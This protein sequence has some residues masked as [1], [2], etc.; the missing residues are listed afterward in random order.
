M[1]NTFDGIIRRARDLGPKVLAVAA[2]ED[3]DVLKAVHHAW[4]LGIIV[5]LLVG[6][7][8]ETCRAAGEEGLNITRF[9]ILPISDKTEACSKA[10]QLV[11]S[12]EASL[13][14]KGF[15]DTAVILKALLDKESGLMSGGLFSHVGVLSIKGYD[16]FFILSDSAMNLAPTLEEK[17]HIIRNAV[18][19]AHALGNPLP[20][21]AVL[22][23]VEKVNPKMQCTLDAAELV[24]MNEAG[25]IEGCMVGGPFALDNAV[26]P[27]AAQHKGIKHPVAGN[28]D[29]LI[30]PDLEAGNLLNKSMEY[31]AFAE[32]AGII[33]G[34]AAP[35]VLTSR[36]SSDAS[37]LNSIALAVLAAMYC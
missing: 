32:K 12:G 22:C 4:E 13:L 30:T 16:R 3:G 26:C 1:I 35:V 7:P 14:M 11:K 21:V 19:V 28:A 31:F 2:C 34:A 9:K 8:E 25:L 10:V 27:R 29:I 18:K 17:A 20:K 37:K 24:K 5:P 36:A 6:D 23:A 33:M 15:V